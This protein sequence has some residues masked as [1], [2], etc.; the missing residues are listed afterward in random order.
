MARPIYNQP[1]YKQLRADWNILMANGNVECRR[2]GQ[3]I[4]RGTPWHLGHP[5]DATPG[6]PTTNTNLWPEH[7]TC[8]TSAGATAGNKLRLNQPQPSR[9]W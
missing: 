8:N 2:C 6:G 4:K 1:T 5:N 7:A 3:P 9:N